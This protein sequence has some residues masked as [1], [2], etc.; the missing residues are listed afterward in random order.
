ME[1]EEAKRESSCVGGRNLHRPLAVTRSWVPPTPPLPRP[2]YGYLE[3][4]LEVSYRKVIAR[5]LG[6]GEWV[7]FLGGRNF[8]KH[9]GDDYDPAVVYFR[10]FV[11][12]FLDIS[13]VDPSG[14]GNNQGNAATCPRV[15]R[16]NLRGANGRA[17]LAQSETKKPLTKTGIKI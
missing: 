16:D 15:G 8:F 6:A 11:D 7:I 12:A 9:L 1:E 3:L 14:G 2:L 4:G 5:Y 17:W 10:G 13:P